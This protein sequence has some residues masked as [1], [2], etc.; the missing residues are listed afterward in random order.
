MHDFHAVN[1]FSAEAGFLG[2]ACRLKRFLRRE[3]ECLLYS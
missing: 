3:R 2:M 1:V